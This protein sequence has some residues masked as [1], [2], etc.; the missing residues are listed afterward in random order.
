VANFSDIDCLQNHKDSTW[1]YG[2]KVQE[3]FI[4]GSDCISKLKLWVDSCYNLLLIWHKDCGPWWLIH[5]GDSLRAGRSGDLIPVE[6]RFSTPV[7][8]GPGAHPAPCPISTV[9]LSPG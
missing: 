4:M 5:N 8:T 3:D 1:S 7:Q 9:S 2:M 6:S